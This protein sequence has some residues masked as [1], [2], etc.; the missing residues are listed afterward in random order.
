[1]RG[2]QPEA[3]GTGVTLLLTLVLVTM[4]MRIVDDTG[5]GLQDLSFVM[6][7]HI[8]PQDLSIQNTAG[9]PFRLWMP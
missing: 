5:K 4:R 2:S 3:E 1:V 6:Q 8:V 7:V 9:A